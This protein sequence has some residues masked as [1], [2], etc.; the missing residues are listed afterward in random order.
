MST[1]SN[2]NTNRLRL[3]QV[4]LNK[5]EKAHLELY[6]SELST[7]YD[8]ILVQEPYIT[9]KLKHIR[10]PNRFRSVYPTDRVKQEEKTT[11]SVI[12]VS[13]ELSTGSWNE[14]T[15]NNNNDITAIQ[16][17]G[18]FGRLTIFNIYNDCNNMDMVRRL[19]QYLHENPIGTPSNENDHML[20]V[21]DFNC[22]SPL[23]DKDEDV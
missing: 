8:I 15:I 2:R 10:P 23:W 19:R 18:E 7:F 11:R 14:I 3:L 5:S 1:Q 22:H 17:T 20:W 13:T 4:N 16:L 6:N 21:G 9:P 12:W